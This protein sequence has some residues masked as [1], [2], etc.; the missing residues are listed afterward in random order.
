MRSISGRLASTEVIVVD[1]GSAD[2]TRTVIDSLSTADFSLRYIF[3]PLP[4]KSRACNTAVREA[5]GQILVFTD[6]D[7]QANL[8]WID[9]ICAP[10]FAGEADAVA[11]G[12]VIAPNLRRGWLTAAHCGWLVTTEG[13]VTTESPCLIGANMA[14]RRE[15]V[16]AVGGFDIEVGPGAIGH[17]EDTL[18]W[19]QVQKAGFKIVS[20]YDVI[21]EHHFDPQRLSRAAFASQARKRGEFYAYV[22]HHWQHGGWKRPYINTV[23]K[24]LRLQIARL[25]HLKDWLTHPSMPEWE[26][27]LLENYYM[28]K[29][30]THERLRPRNYE[31][32]GLKKLHSAPQPLMT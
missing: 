31:R 16:E 9:G 12:I 29:F 25:I 8:N 5:I 11:G 15:V 21:V 10:I 26:L 14:L 13:D 24:W 23:R 19:M 1:N 6:D 22:T 17:A 30:Y 28:F 4:G 2:N 3:E 7:V 20:R 32:Q 27:E 18:F